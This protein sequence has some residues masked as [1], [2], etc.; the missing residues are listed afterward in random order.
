MPEGA[1]EGIRRGIYKLLSRDGDRTK[2]QLLSSG[3]IL[4]EVIK[5]SEIL[6]EEYSVGS[7]IYSVTSFNEL[8]RDGQDVARHNMLHPESAP[9]T[10]YVAE[11]LGSEPAIAATDYMKNYADQIRAFIPAES[12]CVL[13]TDGYGRSDSRE[14]LRT[15]FEINRHY[16]VVATLNE[17]AKRGDVEKSTVAEA[18]S[19]YGIDTNKPNPLFS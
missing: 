9:R 12:Y 18:I 7:D 3:T 13:G 19:K 15:H 8:A 10:A 14:N 5:A 1:E 11:V 6:S 17:L 4:N 2:V 16:V